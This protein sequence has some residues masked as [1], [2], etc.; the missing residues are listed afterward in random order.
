MP[1]LRRGGPG[2][3]VVDLVDPE[4]VYLTEPALRGKFYLPMAHAVTRCDLS[5]EQLECDATAVLGS[6]S[7]VFYVSPRAVYLWT[8]AISYEGGE[9]DGQL[10]RLP[11]DG[12]RPGSVPV[13]G[14]PV[15]QFSFTE[16]AGDNVLRVALRGEGQGDAMWGSEFSGGDLGLLTV[17]LGAFT[18]G[19]QR[20][21]QAALREL[22]PVAGY[23]FHNRFVGDY[24][25]Y[26]ASNYGNASDARFFYA[27][28]V[29][30][31]AA[32]RVE[33][34][35]GVTRFD[36]MGS[37][38]IAI[39]PGSGNSLGFSAVSLGRQAQV[40]D[41]YL[42]PAA[43]EGEVRSQAFFYRADPGSPDGVS[44][45][46]G[47]PVSRTRTGSGGEFLG[48]ASA[49]FFLRRDN[50]SFNP[51]GDLVSRAKA[52]VNDNCEASCVDWYGNARPIFL[53]ERIFALLGYELVEG[54]IENG[55]IREVLRTNFTPAGSMR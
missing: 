52:G 24:L 25:L 8:E 29:D 9:A 45:T 20:M 11:L 23:Q 36:V 37:D 19:S 50:R 51:A 44:G 3:E 7:R 43:S 27:A 31:R 28:P 16:D 53:R 41:V 42:L 48:N 35:H 21:P 34:E 6:W 39:G 5:A 46:L 32:Q 47:L 54:R 40:E 10:Y 2:G 18:D 15:D 13:S 17:P 49:I 4:D 26:A 30:G 14:G 22:P 38:A 33:L 55:A 1:A 12:S